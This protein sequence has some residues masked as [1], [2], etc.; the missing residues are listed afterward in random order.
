VT[1]RVYRAEMY[2]GSLDMRDSEPFYGFTYDNSYLASSLALPLSLS[3]P[4][5][6][7]RYSGEKALPYFEGLL[8]EGEARA[9]IARRLGIPST[10]PARLLKALGRDCAGDISII[11]AD[12]A[13]TLETQ[14]YVLLEGGISRLAENPY[15]EI[16]RLQEETR[17]SLAGGQEKV[18]LFHKEDDSL[19]KSWFIPLSGSPS[20]HIIK[21]G[22]LDARYPHLSLNEFICLRAAALC[23]IRTISV[24]L[25]YPA[26]PLLVVRR[27]DR[28]FSDTVFQGM[29]MVTRLHQEDCCQACGVKSDMKYEHDGGPGFG[30]IRN[31]L[32]KHSQYPIDDISA[33][34]RVGLFNYLIGNCDA[35]SKN[36]SLL[37]NSDGTVSLAPAY[38]LIASTIYDGNYGSKLSR[39]MGMRIGSHENIDRVDA[40]DFD[41]FTREI[42]IRTNQLKAIGEELEYSLH[43]AFNAAGE[44]A[45]ALGFTAADELVSRIMENSSTRSKVLLA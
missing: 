44:E 17:L 45:F 29:N 40:A 39:N 2:I 38:D 10:S 13:L 34:V 18:A 25:L 35:H 21:P 24:D 1:L 5:S 23:G 31:L 36:F 14:R 4:L 37:Q 41:E 33:L 8:P 32:S 27:Y 7:S 26:T 11:E 19:E 16:T 12:E 6:D 22:L 15:E 3:L 28:L 20:T 43:T 30:R 9:A 42:H